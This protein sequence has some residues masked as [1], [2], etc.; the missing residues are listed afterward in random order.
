M[1]P[2]VGEI[3]F[4]NLGLKFASLF[5]ALLLYAHVVTDQ[6]REQAIWVPVKLVGLPDSLA[7]V[8]RPPARIG[9]SVRGKWKDLIRLGLRS[10]YLPVDLAEARPGQFQRMITA[11]DVI[12]KA[13]PAE[14]TKLVTIREVLEPRT[15][16]IEIQPRSVKTVP[17]VARVVGTPVPGY[18]LLAPPTANP[19]SVRLE[20]P[21]SI[22]AATDTLFTLPV[23]ITGERERIVRQVDFDL[24]PYLLAAVPRRCLV[25]LRIARAEPDSS[26]RYP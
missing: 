10:H 24:G 17:V 5:L 13:I 23:D 26:A 9:V 6:Q 15:V 14:M 4:H 11:E 3:L 1:W 21:A 19:D 7:V 22:L 25:T 8:G 18:R 16:D 2:R 20:G 12:A